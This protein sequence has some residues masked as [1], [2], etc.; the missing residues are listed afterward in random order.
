MKKDI[1]NSPLTCNTNEESASDNE[2]IESLM[3]SYN[4]EK[5]ET[6]KIFADTSISIGW[7]IFAF[8]CL[9]VIKKWLFLKD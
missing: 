8:C 4:F 3:G 5:V 6:Y 9:N 2:L 1:R 7:L